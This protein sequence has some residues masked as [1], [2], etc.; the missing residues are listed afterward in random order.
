[1]TAACNAK[2]DGPLLEAC[3]G[4]AEA[5]Y[6]AVRDFGFGK[7]GWEGTQAEACECCLLCNPYV[8]C[9]PPSLAGHVNDPVAL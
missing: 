7:D 9:V 3:L 4:M 5:Y 1:M 2:A 8:E 6:R